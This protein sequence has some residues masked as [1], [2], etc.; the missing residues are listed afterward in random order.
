VVQ[1]LQ[2]RLGNV[3]RIGVTGG[4]DGNFGN[5]TYNAVV[6]FQRQNGLG[7]DGVVGQNTWKKILGL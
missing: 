3:F 1:L 2:E 6:E 4:Y 7:K 5:G